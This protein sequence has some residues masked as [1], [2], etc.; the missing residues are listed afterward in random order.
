MGAPKHPAISTVREYNIRP[1]RK[2]LRSSF[3]NTCFILVRLLFF[4]LTNHPCWFLGIIA[5]KAM[6]V[7]KPS[8]YF[9]QR[10]TLPL[11]IP[12]GLYPEQNAPAAGA[13]GAFSINMRLFPAFKS[14]G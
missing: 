8:P 1:Q 11:L 4:E 6:D 3:P 7:K 5:F 14:G 12:A 9:F 2:L 10:Q 13:A